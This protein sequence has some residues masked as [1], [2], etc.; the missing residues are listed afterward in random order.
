MDG[1][2][3]ETLTCVSG[4]CGVAV[5]PSEKTAKK[6]YIGLKKVA[7]GILWLTLGETF[8]VG[9][10]K[11]LHLLVR[12]V[13]GLKKGHKHTYVIFEWSLTYRHIKS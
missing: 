3:G 8:R 10:G 12:W 5:W 4:V 7:Y 6:I 13:G 9:H 1:P 2:L 11:C